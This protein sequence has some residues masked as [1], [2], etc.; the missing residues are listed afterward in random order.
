MD[1]IIL[2]LVVTA[3]SLQA[4]AVEKV[5][6]D[7]RAYI[8]EREG[9]DHMRGEPPDP[10]DKQ[11]AKEVSREINELCKGTDRRLAG[12]KR[13]YASDQRVMRHLNRF[14]SNVEPDPDRAPR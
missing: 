13:K 12:L 2:L 3:L 1:R 5:P 14:D 8:E 7:V 4:S 6:A 10:R 9:C 11:R